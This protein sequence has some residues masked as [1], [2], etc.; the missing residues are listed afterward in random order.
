[1]ASMTLFASEIAA[2]IGENRY[3]TVEVAACAVW[4]RHAPKAFAE[5]CTRHGVRV[6]AKQLDLQV[7][8]VLQ[9]QVHQATQAATPEQ[10][11]QRM[12][13]VALSHANV[14]KSAAAMSAV[15]VAVKK[16]DVS[17]PELQQAVATAR[18]VCDTTAAAALTERVEAVAAQQ[19]IVA[20]EHKKQTQQ[21][22]QS[23]QQQLRR[24]VDQLAK[25][26]QEFA[27]EI[28]QVATQLAAVATP[29][30][31]E[32][33]RAVIYTERGT[34]DE[35]AAVDLYAAASE[36]TV[37]AQPRQ[38]LATNVTYQNMQGK[39]RNVRIIGYVDGLTEVDGEV[40]IVEVK[41][42]QNRLFGKVP[43]YELIQIMTYMAMANVS[44]ADWVERYGQKHNTVA[45]NFDP[46]EWAA[47][48]EGVQWFASGLEALLG[49][50][51]DDIESL[52]VGLVGQLGPD[53][54]LVL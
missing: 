2:C 35:Q 34:R 33:T 29:A 1:M 9:S 18:A 40:R 14:A 50:S 43:R 36:R 48:E 45:I 13:V 52:F 32:A 27:Q 41:N 5:A 49:G 3:K 15:A 28:N 12:A 21:T 20:V 53:K 19:A 38:Q 26:K 31:R 10:F 7:A 16:Q 4:R 39:S 23:Q 8:P 46:K 51:A 17:V 25:L 44:K 30:A 47:I 37:H 6:S 22:D 42:R 11:A 24:Q 54:L